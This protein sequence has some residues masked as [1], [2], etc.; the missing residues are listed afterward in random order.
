MRP[1]TQ[2]ESERRLWW[3]GV[4]TLIGLLYYGAVLRSRKPNT[5]WLNGW[6]QRRGGLRL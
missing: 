5:V 6:R 3:L 4:P 1:L 2:Q